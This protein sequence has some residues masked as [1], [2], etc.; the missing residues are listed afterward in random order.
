LREALT[1]YENAGLS[2]TWERAEAMH[3][4]G[5]VLSLMGRNDAA[6]AAYAEARQIELDGSPN[7]ARK[8]SAA[9]DLL[10]ESIA[11]INGGQPL[12]ARDR[13]LASLELAIAEQGPRGELVSRAHVDIAAVC[14]ALG[15]LDCLRSHSEQADEISQIAVG[16]TSLTRIDVLS[17]VGVAAVRDGRPQDAATAFEQALAIAQHHTAADSLQVGL[18][19]GNLAGALHS[20]GQDQRAYLLAAHAVE[21][22]EKHLPDNDASFVPALLVLAELEVDRNEFDAARRTLARVAAI[23][24]SDDIETHRTIDELLTRC[25]E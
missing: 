8:T 22:L 3:T 9:V 11:L 1:V 17:S 6:L 12:V 20:I 16:A 7:S 18:A 21:T 4:L 19:E 14:D 13:A 15:D 5:W 24:P 2:A 10:N 23:V 25:G